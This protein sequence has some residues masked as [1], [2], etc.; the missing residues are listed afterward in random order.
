QFVLEGVGLL[1]WAC[2]AARRDGDRRL[3]TRP[4]IPHAPVMKHDPA[5]HPLDPR[6]ARMRLIL[7]SVVGLATWL[8]VPWRIAAIERALL[9]WDL[10]GLLLLGFALLIITRSDSRET[11]RRAAAY[12]PG[13]RLVWIIV[14]A[15][16]AFS[17]FAAAAVLGQGHAGA[18]AT[19][20]FT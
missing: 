19:E 12:D 2:V 9:A 15:A 11:R 10:A 13:R 6:A 4:A 5:F 3:G 1:T 7:A 18:P 14:L 8:G 17:L 20:P 16:S